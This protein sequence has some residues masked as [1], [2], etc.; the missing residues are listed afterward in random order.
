ML[1]HKVKRRRASAR[2]IMYHKLRLSRCS[3]REGDLQPGQRLLQVPTHVT[4]DMRKEALEGVDRELRIG[5]I[6]RLEPGVG[7]A[8]QAGR[9]GDEKPLD[10]DRCEVVS[11]RWV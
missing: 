10:P 1:P 5:Q 4:G 3:G 9:G 11:H 2:A 6:L 7:E 8:R